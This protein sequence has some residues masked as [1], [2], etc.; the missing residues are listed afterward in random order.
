MPQ[1]VSLVGLAQFAYPQNNCIMNCSIYN[2]VVVA[3]FESILSSRELWCTNVRDVVGDRNEGNQAMR[4]IRSAVVTKSVPNEIKRKILRQSRLF[5]LKEDW[6]EYAFCFCAG[7]E[8]DYMWKNYAKG[9]GGEGC[10]GLAIVFDYKTLFCD[11]ESG[12]RYALGRVLYDPDRQNEIVHQQFDHAI[13]LGRKLAI[14][15]REKR[16]FWLEVILWLLVSGVRFKAPCWNQ[17]EEIRLMLTPPDS[18]NAFPC[19]GKE[20]MKVP[21]RLEAVRRV[22]RGSRC[23]RSV[24]DLRRWLDER[25][26][27]GV[28]VAESETGA[29]QPADC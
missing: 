22:V 7:G 18:K 21:Y 25:G 17:D 2:T 28:P 5:G 19:L 27:P 16:Q 8:Q 29:G 11:C 24:A 20:R 3:G 14:P 13:Q 15:N 23:E 9:G 12:Q 4:I 26:C 6:H 10:S 1:G